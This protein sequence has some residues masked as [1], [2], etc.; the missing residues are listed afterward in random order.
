[1]K[2]GDNEPEPDMKQK[3]EH[4]RSRYSRV[5]VTGR[6]QHR[7]QVYRDWCI[8]S[9]NHAQLRDI[10][11]GPCSNPFPTPFSWRG[12]AVSHAL[13]TR[14]RALGRGEPVTVGR[15][16]QYN[17]KLLQHDNDRL[18]QENGRLP[19]EN[20]RLRYDN[21][22]QRDD[23]DRLQNDNA[24][25]PELQEQLTELER[26]TGRDDDGIALVVPGQRR[27]FGSGPWMRRRSGLIHISNPP[28][29]YIHQSIPNPFVPFR[30]AG[31]PPMFWWLAIGWQCSTPPR[32]RQT[33]SHDLA[34][35]DPENHHP[36][37]PHPP[38]PFLPR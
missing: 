5:E 31:A 21:D 14:R 28:S 34:C 27:L 8:A 25:I 1:M 6:E 12:D 11:V 35:L 3:H 15:K 24:A 17:N 16:G 33:H 29:Q 22:L 32:R 13:E 36:G 18:Y 38:K 19:A 4:E 10:V 20:Q 7:Q 9:H 23:I 30:S 26:A 2:T 37:D